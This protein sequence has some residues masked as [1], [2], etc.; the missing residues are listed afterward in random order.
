VKSNFWKAASCSMVEVYQLFVGIYCLDFQSERVSWANKQERIACCFFGL[1]FC[2]KDGGCM[3]L[4]KVIIFYQSAHCHIPE[5][6]MFL[7]LR[8]LYCILPELSVTL[9]KLTVVTVNYSKC[10]HHD[11]QKQGEPLVLWAWGLLYPLSLLVAWKHFMARE[12]T[13][14]W[15]ILPESLLVHI[16][17]VE[18]I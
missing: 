17:I 18:I 10:L 9:I 16:W 5:N 6:N 15:N 7:T 11:S 8:S 4:R 2:P 14:C 3:F 1:I 12:T 13:V